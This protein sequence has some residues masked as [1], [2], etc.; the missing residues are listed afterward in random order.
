MEEY[1]SI[2]G[3]LKLLQRESEFIFPVELWMLNDKLTKNGWRFA[4]LAEH[5]EKWAG[6]PI[7]TAYV[8]GGRVVGDGHNQ[9]TRTDKNGEPYQSF[10]DSTAERIVGAISDD[11]NDVRIEERDDAVWVVGK[12]FLWAWYAHELCMQIADDAEQ[13]RKMSVSIEALVTDGYMD[14]DVEVETA[15]TPLGVTVLGHG[16]APA[17]DAAHIAMLTEIGSELKELKLRAASY[18]EQANAEPDPEPKPQNNSSRNGVEKIMRLPK[19]QIKKLQEKFPEQKLLAAE[20]YENGDIVVALMS[21]NG[22][23]SI[24]TLASLDETIYPEKFVSVNATVHICAGEGK[25]DICVDASDMTECAAEGAKECLDRAECAEKELKEC[26]A[27]IEKMIAAE[28]AR[29]LSAAKSM[30]SATLDAFN[31]N[32]EDKVDMKVLEAL[33]KDIEA[34][35]YTALCDENGVW[36]GD[37]MVATQVKAL[38]ADAVMEFDKTAAANRAK[39]EPMTWGSVKQASAAP[40]TIGELFASKNNK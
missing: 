5:R 36:N 28:N 16:V 29:R 24:Y 17:V 1:R 6:V 35:K 12:G 26:Q 7:L 33:N 15:Y 19:Q 23:T 11:P 31:A 3:E 40:G 22:S 4:N 13:G 18:I 27:T 32:R 8:N 10:T 9:A 34:G 37:A 21:P 38:C 30:A 14:G 20:K 25:E 2:E 39:P